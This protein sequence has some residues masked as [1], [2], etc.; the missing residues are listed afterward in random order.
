MKKMTAVVRT[1]MSTICLSAIAGTAYA[2]TFCTCEDWNNNG[3]FGVVSRQTVGNVTKQVVDGNVGN[4]YDCMSF[5]ATMSICKNNF[6]ACEDWDKD[7]RFGAV[8]Y[9]GLKKNTRKLVKGDVGNYYDCVS[10]KSSLSQC[11]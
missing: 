2:G 7:G 10:Y 5:Q 11:Q 1:V 8:V 4:Y 9:F 6:C 3:S